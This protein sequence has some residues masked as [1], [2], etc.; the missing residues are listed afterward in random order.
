MFWE[1]MDF[2]L[3]NREARVSVCLTVRGRLF[4]M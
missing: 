1:E 3:G 2:E 4:Q